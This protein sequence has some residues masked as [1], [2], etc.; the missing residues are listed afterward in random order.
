MYQSY[1]HFKNKK[2]LLGQHL[3][4]RLSLYPVVTKHNKGLRFVLCFVDTYSK[5]ASCATLKIQKGITNFDACRIILDRCKCKPNKIWVERVNENE[6]FV[7][8]Q[9]RNVFNT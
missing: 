9:Y 4:W 8:R 2:C 1:E 6:I 7:A 3:R 5:Y